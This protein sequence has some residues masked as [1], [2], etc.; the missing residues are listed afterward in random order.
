[1]AWP[2]LHISLLVM[3]ILNYSDSAI[4]ISLVY[5]LFS[6]N[7]PVQNLFI[8]RHFMIDLPVLPSCSALMSRFSPPCQL[9]SRFGLFLGSEG[10]S[11]SELTL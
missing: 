10:S 11:L 9:F 2:E 6:K 5:S 3:N 1:M 7:F 8:R 4:F